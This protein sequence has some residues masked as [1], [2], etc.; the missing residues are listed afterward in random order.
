[1]AKRGAESQITKEGLE[2]G[3]GMDSGTDGNSMPQRATAAQLAKRKIA[4]ARTSGRSGSG[5]SNQSHGHVTAP[6]QLSPSPFLNLQPN[7]FN[8]TNNPQNGFASNN[9]E[10]TSSSHSTFNPNTFGNN[11]S[12]A[13]HA[14]APPSSS[15]NFNLNGSSP[16]NNPF[17]SLTNGAAGTSVSSGPRNYQGSIFSFSTPNPPV[18]QG[19]TVTQ[20]Q[21]TRSILDNPE[22][23]NSTPLWAQHSPFS[24]TQYAQPQQSNSTNLFTSS[25]SQSAAPPSFINTTTQS[26]QPSVSFGFPT[27]NQQQPSSFTFGH[28]G[29]QQKPA[30]SSSLFSQPP[31]VSFANMFGAL[32]QQPSSI[33]ADLFGK[34]AHSPALNNHSIDSVEA[35]D[36]AMSISPPHETL[37]NSQSGGNNNGSLLSR[38]SE[39]PTLPSDAVLNLYDDTP[40]RFNKGEQRS[41]RRPQLSTLEVPPQSQINGV[42]GQSSE[43]GLKSVTSKSL[44]N[45]SPNTNNLF[46]GFPTTARPNDQEFEGPN[47]GTREDST[48]PTIRRSDSHEP[49]TSKSPFASSSSQPTPS[50]SSSEPK[51]SMDHGKSIFTNS[52]DIFRSKQSRNIVQSPS[53]ATSVSLTPLTEEQVNTFVPPSIP[54]KFSEAQ[55]QEYVIR[56][57]LRSLNT[58][59]KKHIDI[60]LSY[61]VTSATIRLYEL[62]QEEILASGGLAIDTTGLKR[63]FNDDGF[64]DEASV[65]SKRHN[66]NGV[67][68]NANNVEARTFE[69]TASSNKRKSDEDISKHNGPNG[70]T[71]SAKK[72][73]NDVPYP[74]LPESQTS[75]TASL[76]A[77]IANSESAGSA[78]PGNPAPDRHTPFQSPQT[79]AESLFAFTT[80][81]IGLQDQ[82]RATGSPNFKPSTIDL[83]SSSSLFAPKIASSGDS[84]NVQPS[85][86]GFLFRPASTST[87]SPIKPPAFGSGSTS[88]DITPT[89]KAFSATQSSQF[90]VPSFGAPSGTNYLDQFGQKAKKNEEEMAKEAKAKRK[91][92]E[93]DSEDED[94]NEEEW[95]RQYEEE[96]RA[97]RQK[98][99]AAQGNEGLK[100][101]FTRSETSDKAQKEGANETVRSKVTCEKAKPLPPATGNL[102]SFLLGNSGTPSVFG[103]P[104]SNV[105]V[106][107]PFINSK[108]QRS[109]GEDDESNDAEDEDEP[110]THSAQQ[111]GLGTTDASKP[112]STSSSRSIFDR[113][114][115]NADGTPRREKPPTSEKEQNNASELQNL[116]SAHNKK[117]SSSFS[118]GEPGTSQALSSSSSY[119][120]AAELSSKTNPK[121][122]S[123]RSIFEAP[124][125]ET[126]VDQD[127]ASPKS[128][129]DKT[130]KP[131]SPIKFGG[132]SNVPS[133]NITESSP[134]KSAFN[135]HTKLFGST[136]AS[137]SAPSLFGSK[138]VP[139]S[140]PSQAS[141]FSTSSS[142]A[143]KTN[144]GFSFTAPPVPS[145]STPTVGFGFGGP[146]KPFASLAAPSV[147]DSANSSR[148]TSPGLSTG[149][150]SAAEGGEDDTQNDVQID[151]AGGRAGEEN[152]NVLF[153]VKAK[154]MELDVNMN[155]EE[156]KKKPEWFVRG[157]GQ[158]RVLKH[159]DTGKTRVLLRAGP[160]GKIALNAALMSGMNYKH[161]GE[162][163]ITFGA[164]TGAGKVAKWTVRVGK[165]E[166]AAKLA[167]LLE[168]NKSN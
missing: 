161:A 5:R 79:P 41:V 26:E 54:E 148:A 162:K 131:D 112:S 69:P 86:G 103:S 52:K 62:R 32:S 102:G 113:I 27:N 78:T 12:F 122:N 23:D 1:M 125:V 61:P 29:N 168:E 22:V 9:N 31:Q 107:N 120:T 17:L 83:A 87:T 111:T 137:A 158:L 88:N 24:Q 73:R 28:S 16:F 159:R 53:P 136:A 2:R 163:T 95:E 160:A 155:V 96:Q 37:Q 147:L 106:S 47:K 36:D 13:P 153:E 71:D 11:N 149:G 21:P 124:P 89:T 130:W 150:E 121:G 100:F 68:S 74:T 151:I 91:A 98:I 18:L 77:Q 166:D 75:K 143:P 140:S 55:K 42:S 4:A 117:F 14:S 49:T 105:E 33:G 119:R 90:K 80:E 115:T 116:L 19:Q 7:T 70:I 93:F 76:F 58:A 64:V 85:T 104:S 66:L 127:T 40:S 94:A 60:S 65:S 39:T 126:T 67:F 3:E 35:P 50:F 142:T 145:A 6:Q 10:P 164:A 156:T 51:T 128:Q 167:L 101:T 141:V 123:G 63:K 97:K 45:L 152:E 99:E 72:A 110:E 154:A 43:Q 34:F 56:Y 133:L 30:Q 81:P 114:E 165:K 144:V 138:T 48:L 132:S 8:G 59:F 108:L 25:S 109:N 129:F 92:D 146:P 157:V 134:G 15:F 84:G 139:V 38:V 44:F 82:S 135:F 46:S 57:R 20:G 118:F